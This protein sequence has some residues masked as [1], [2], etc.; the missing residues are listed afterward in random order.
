MISI[1][2]FSFSSVVQGHSAI[3]RYYAM[4]ANEVYALS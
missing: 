1:K 3:L 4:L 2:I